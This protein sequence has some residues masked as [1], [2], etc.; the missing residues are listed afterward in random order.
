MKEYGVQRLLL[1]FCPVLHSLTQG[2]L[3][4][5]PDSKQ[6]ESGFFFGQHRQAQLSLSGRLRFIDPLERL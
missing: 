4:F 5:N 1:L 6:R 2:L 3:Q